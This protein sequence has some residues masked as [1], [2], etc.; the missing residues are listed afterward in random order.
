MVIHLI[1][2]LTLVIPHY[3]RK[4]YNISSCVILIP[5]PWLCSDSWW[6]K[7]EIWLPRIPCV[8]PESWQLR[9]RLRP[10]PYHPI[11]CSLRLRII[12]YP[13]NRHLRVWQCRHRQ[14]SGLYKDVTP[15][16]FLQGVRDWPPPGRRVHVSRGDKYPELPSPHP[17]LPLPYSLHPYTHTNRPH[18]GDGLSENSNGQ[19]HIYS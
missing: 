16:L 12:H 19:S 4:H 17:T 9:S 7:D 11:Y 2:P 18:P 5:N 6:R 1:C 15:G 8:L 10:S 14:R 13:V 3:S